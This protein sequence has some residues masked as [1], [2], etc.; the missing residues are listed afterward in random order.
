MRRILAG[1]LAFAALAGCGQS[2][3][4][5]TAVPTTLSA[6]VMTPDAT[7]ASAQPAVEPDLP[8]VE[9]LDVATG[10]KVA[11]RS[12]VPASTPLLVW[13]WAPH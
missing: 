1:L 4:T 2:S 7:A 5:R 9:V 12:F 13:M 6:P 8:A 3:G 11:L 10:R